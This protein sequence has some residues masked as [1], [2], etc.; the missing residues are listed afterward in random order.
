MQATGDIGRLSECSLR[1]EEQIERD[2]GFLTLKL[3][4]LETGQRDVAAQVVHDALSSS[5]QAAPTSRPPAVA[6]VGAGPHSSEFTPGGF[7][8]VAYQSASGVLPQG[9]PPPASRP[10]KR[11]ADSPEYPAATRRRV[12]LLDPGA[13]APV[14]YS[15][16]YRG[17]HTVDYSDEEL[18]RAG[19]DRAPVAPAQPVGTSGLSRSGTNSSGRGSG[20]FSVSSN[21]RTPML[22]FEGTGLP[23]CLL[24][25]ESNLGVKAMTDEEKASALIGSVSHKVRSSLRLIPGLVDHPNAKVGQGLRELFDDSTN[26][27]MM[28]GQ[29]HAI[30]RMRRKISLP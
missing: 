20:S 10:P 24:A 5:S 14:G 28:H 23:G 22:L 19:E 30:K 21:Y 6:Q 16:P 7:T 25:F 8:P 29:F 18:E 3:Q 1:L 12:S 9:P 4:G 26:R 11:N 27:A 13:P 2:V 17:L 15:T